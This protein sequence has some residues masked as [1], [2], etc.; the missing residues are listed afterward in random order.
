MMSRFFPFSATRYPVLIVSKPSA[1]ICS[2]TTFAVK[3]PRRA[4]RRNGVLLL[5]SSR[6]LLNLDDDK[7][8]VQV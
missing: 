5:P 1:I 2:K 6:C 8:V 7:K 3:M 4:V